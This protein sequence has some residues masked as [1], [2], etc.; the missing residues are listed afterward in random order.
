MVGQPFQHIADIDHQRARWRGNRQP[1]PA[2]IQQFEPRFLRPQQQ[3]DEID[4]AMRRLR[5]K[6]DEGFEPKLIHTVRGMGYVL[7]QQ[8]E[9]AC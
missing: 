6:I 8:D 5:N 3:R 7:E 9:L 2:A 1:A 4:V